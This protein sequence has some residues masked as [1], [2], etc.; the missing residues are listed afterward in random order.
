MALVRCKECGR[1]VSNTAKSCPSCGY[2]VDSICWNCDHFSDTCG[3]CDCCNASNPKD[4]SV[5]NQKRA[6]PGFSNNSNYYA[7]Y[8]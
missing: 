2:T 3:E 8:D 6:C 1:S 5:W 7:D 4:F